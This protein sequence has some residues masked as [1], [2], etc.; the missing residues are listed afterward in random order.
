MSRVNDM[1]AR[2]SEAVT[3]FVKDCDTVLAFLHAHTT[4]V[5]AQAKRALAMKAIDD[6]ITEMDVNIAQLNSFSAAAHEC[7]DL[8][9]PEV[10]TL[11]IPI[12][13][14]DGVPM[15]GMLYSEGISVSQ[16]RIDYTRAQSY[17]PMEAVHWDV[18]IVDDSGAI[19]QWVTAD[20]LRLDLQY[21]LGVFYGNTY[22]TSCIKGEYGRFSISMTTETYLGT[23]YP[24]LEINIDPQTVYCVFF[25][26]LY[27]SAPSGSNSFAIETKHAFTFGSSDF[28]ISPDGLWA[29]VVK[30][31][32]DIY[33]IGAYGGNVRFK[34]T[35]RPPYPNG[36]CALITPRNTILF[37]FS[38]YILEFDRNGVL[39]R[40]LGVD[41][42]LYDRTFSTMLLRNNVLVTNDVSGLLV[43]R[44]SDA[45][46]LRAIPIWD[47]GT[48]I[49]RLVTFSE[50]GGVLMVRIGVGII[51]IDLE[52]GCE[53]VVFRDEAL[54]RE[55]IVSA[56]ASVNA[57]EVL[58]ARE[59]GIMLCNMDT[60]TARAITTCNN[61]RSMVWSRGRLYVSR[62]D[63]REIRAYF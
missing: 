3:R 62:A 41:T 37:G 29:V 21:E 9:V 40:T 23:F 53:T 2:A 42:G 35:L 13:D 22:P 60:N 47:Y 24:Y 58:L 56:I 15:P 46:F 26:Q 5:R 50:D 63:T 55:S 45:V 30:H 52:T 39:I 36:A 43:Y 25:E 34:E 20:H 7:V 10:N 31:G 57:H 59:E 14:I 19:A 44:Y 18:E 49:R 16:T 6:A 8:R 33:D 27:Q 32:I 48:I 51:R 54:S 12:A 28:A 17:R 4:A 1:C 11:C 38:I 61:P